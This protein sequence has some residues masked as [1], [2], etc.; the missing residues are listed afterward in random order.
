MGVWGEGE[1]MGG[2]VDLGV[3]GVN[4]GPGVIVERVYGRVGVGGL[5]TNGNFAE[6]APIARV[7]A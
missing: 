6:W 7:K 4:E 2:W 5:G 3:G 1:R